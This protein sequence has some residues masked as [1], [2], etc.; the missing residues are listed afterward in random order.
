MRKHVFVKV[1]LAALMVGSLAASANADE[2]YRIKFKVT[3]KTDATISIAFAQAQTDTGGEL[4]DDPDRSKGWFNV[5][6][7]ETK[8][9]KPGYEMSPFHTVYYYARSQGGKRVWGGSKPKEED[10]PFGDRA[11]WIHPEKRFNVKGEE[12]PGGKRVYFEA[13]GYDY[14]DP[15]VE[16]DLTANE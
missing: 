16:L 13:V 8:T 1:L 3:N 10:Y 4:H 12:I 15:T 5:K 11:F 14:S 6:P 2:D 9:I 7:G